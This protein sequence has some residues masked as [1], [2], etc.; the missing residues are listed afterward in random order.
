MN[1][2]LVEGKIIT[3]QYV[4]DMLDFI[5]KAE[6]N[7]QA[8]KILIG[9]F[10]KLI[11]QG[12]I[13]FAYTYADNG[14]NRLR[15]RIGRMA[16]FRTGTQRLK[17]IPSNRW[18]KTRSKN[19][20]AIRYYD[21]GRMGWRA[22][23]KDCFVVATSFYDI[24][25]KKWKDDPYE[26]GFTSNWNRI[27]GLNLLKNYIPTS[28][29]ESPEELQKRHQIENKEAKKRIEQIRKTQLKNKQK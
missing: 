21:F 13:T 6:D 18:P 1:Y 28:N 26:A 9:E 19:T 11:L 24:R 12:K 16:G 7:T 17:L 3:A 22:L 8:R 14:E 20:T 10:Q 25:D 23:R 27:K 5:S 15:G 2:T 4:L 29:A